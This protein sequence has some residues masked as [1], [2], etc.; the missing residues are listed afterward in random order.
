MLIYFLV[1]MTCGG[2]ILLF[3]RK[4]VTLVLR[5]AFLL[6]QISSTTP[7]R[8][9]S[10]VVK[11]S[12]L[13]ITIAEGAPYRF[14]LTDIH[15]VWSGGRTA[16]KVA[17]ALVHP[18]AGLPGDRFVVAPTVDGAITITSVEPSGA[19]VARAVLYRSPLT[20]Q[21]PFA[22]IDTRAAW[23]ELNR[24]MGMAAGQV[25]GS[26]CLGAQGDPA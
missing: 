3:R 16:P 24:V 15:L 17:A 2:L 22:P 7:Q 10:P 23:V 5:C 14:G 19:V 20:A 11:G 1:A 8:S 9:S 4:I 13:C 18:L 12:A 26:A 21:P 6:N 25:S